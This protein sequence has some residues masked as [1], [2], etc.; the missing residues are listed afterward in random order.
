M[1]LDFLFGP[2][3]KPPQLQ[4]GA[5][6]AEYRLYHTHPVTVDPLALC[7]VY[8]LFHPIGVGGFT[9]MI[10]RKRDLPAAAL[11]VVC[12]RWIVHALAFIWT[13]PALQELALEIGG[14]CTSVDFFDMAQTQTIA[15]RAIAG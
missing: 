10:Y 14:W 8:P 7:T 6:I 11:T 15:R 9:S 5:D 1:R 3:T 13:R 4:V 2:Q 12:T